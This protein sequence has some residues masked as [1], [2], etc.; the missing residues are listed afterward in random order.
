MCPQ[1]RS[2]PSPSPRR[3]LT[4]TAESKGMRDAF[5][6]SQFT[7]SCCTRQHVV[8]ILRTLAP[9]LGTKW[10]TRGS[11]LAADD[12]AAKGRA[13][14]SSSRRQQQQQQQDDSQAAGDEGLSSKCADATVLLSCRICDPEVSA[15]RRPTTPP[16][17]PCS[18]W[19]SAQSARWPGSAAPAQYRRPPS[20]QQALWRRSTQQDLRSSCC[21]WRLSHVRRRAPHAGG[22]GHQARRVRRHVQR[23]VCR[24]RRRL[25]HL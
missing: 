3:T 18:A 1:V 16:P 2:A 7:C 12:A 9:A 15:Y 20:Q 22:P 23:V 8:S 14:A 5:L 6:R 10:S 17:T 24:L 21:P 11:S 25:L 19:P 4:C 13:P